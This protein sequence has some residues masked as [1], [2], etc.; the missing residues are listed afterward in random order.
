MI[1]MSVRLDF[2]SIA[3]LDLGSMRFMD[4]GRLPVMHG[5]LVTSSARV[6]RHGV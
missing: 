3:G 2:I 4:R 1:T 6:E 5:L